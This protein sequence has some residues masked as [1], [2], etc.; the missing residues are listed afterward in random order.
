VK[1]EGI[2]VE[3]G[4][5]LMGNNQLHIDYGPCDFQKHGMGFLKKATGFVEPY[6]LPFLFINNVIL[7]LRQLYLFCNFCKNVTERYRY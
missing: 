2:I 7:K 4:Q 6:S 1:E 3:L 5:L